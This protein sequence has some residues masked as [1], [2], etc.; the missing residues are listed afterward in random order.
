MVYAKAQHVERHRDRGEDR[1]HVKP[2]ATLHVKLHNLR[3][4]CGPWRDTGLVHVDFPHVSGRR[5]RAVLS[6]GWEA[7][8]LRHV[9]EVIP[10]PK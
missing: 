3:Y 7:L 4:V 2:Y 8:T 1:S 9:S 5:R 10:I 6:A